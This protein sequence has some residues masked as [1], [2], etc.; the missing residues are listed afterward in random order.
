VTAGAA[1]LPSSVAVREVGPRDGLQAEQPVAPRLRAKLVVALIAAGVRTVEAVSFVS[2]KAVPAMAGA[3]DVL[4]SV[5]SAL[6]GRSDGA[7][8]GHGRPPRIV[9]L[10]PNRRG[11]E[12][13]LEA[14]VDELTVT[15]SAS[16]T[17]NERNVRMGI[18]E[19]VSEIAAIASLAGGASI[20]VDAVVSCAFGSPYEGAIAPAAVA[21]LGGRLLDGGAA[22]LTLADTTG[23]ASPRTVADVVGAVRSSTGEVDLGLH[24]HDSRGTAL[25]NCYAALQLGVARFDAS[26]GGLGGSPFATGSAGNVA[27]EELVGLL[28]DL[29][30][31]TGISVAGLLE[32]GEMAAAMIGHR[33]ASRLAATASAPSRRDGRQ[34]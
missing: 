10:V 32:A 3:A 14:G 5:R 23:M 1:G 13:A 30:V 27:T 8:A 22:A 26:V 31:E 17:Y 12:M 4:E 9:A 24:L 11:A 19:S 33:L 2:P 21:D 20:P 25:V 6:A 15:V 18:D 28:D 16:A 34:P 29:G 7:G